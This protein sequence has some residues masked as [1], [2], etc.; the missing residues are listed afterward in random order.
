MISLL[1]HLKTST[2][3]STIPFKEG[4]RI[5]PL[6]GE[7]SQQKK[8]MKKIYLEEIPTNTKEEISMLYN[9]GVGLEELEYLIDVKFNKALSES[10]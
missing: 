9:L 3:F 6:N 10:S 7:H 2:L 1:F 4:I 8:S 5:Q